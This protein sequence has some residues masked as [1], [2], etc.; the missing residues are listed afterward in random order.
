MNNRFPIP[1]TGAITVEW[2]DNFAPERYLLVV[3]LYTIYPQAG[4]IL[5]GGFEQRFSSDSGF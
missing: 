1:V 3:S 2:A 4:D 5:Q